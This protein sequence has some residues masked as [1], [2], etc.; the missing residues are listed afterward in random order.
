MM[1]L[2][3]I[4]LASP[5]HAQ[6]RGAESAAAL[7][8]PRADV[9]GV[10][11]VFGQVAGILGP[12]AGPTGLA[13]QQQQ[14]KED[15]SKTVT[16]R[17]DARATILRART[18]EAQVEGLTVGDFAVVQV[19]RSGTDLTAKRVVFDVDPFGPIRFFSVTGTLLRFNRAGT[20]VLLS[21]PGGAAR[22][23]ILTSNTRYALDGIPTETVPAL[24]HNNVLTVNVHLTDRG[25][26]AQAVNL[27]STR[28]ALLSH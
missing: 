2:V 11:R 13:I 26:V 7:P 4:P 14:G 20:Q 15:T 9:P 23:I 16:I 22:W 1:C 6:Q 8:A 21:L 24:Q 27:K 19:V 25:W 10:Q 12:A 3:M 18:A 28:G 5:A 17:L